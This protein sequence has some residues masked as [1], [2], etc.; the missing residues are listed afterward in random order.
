MYVCMYVYTH[1]Q[2]YS[3]ARMCDRIFSLYASLRFLLTSVAI[4]QLNLRVEII[5]LMKLIAQKYREI[6]RSFKLSNLSV[7][8][9]TPSKLEYTFPVVLCYTGYCIRY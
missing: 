4:C 7:S 3:L 6:L 2:T 8:Y 5:F 1:T 9:L